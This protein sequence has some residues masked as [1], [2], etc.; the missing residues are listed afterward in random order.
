MRGTEGWRRA[1]WVAGACAAAGVAVA[2]GGVALFTHLAMQ[3]PRRRRRFSTVEGLP[4]E[5]VD[6]AALDGTP[7]CGWYVPAAE[8]R[9]A[10]ILC[11]GY[12]GNRESL[13]PH[14]RF[15]HAA[16]YSCL[17]FDFRAAG[18]SRGRFCTFGA[19]ES[20]DARGAARWL[21]ERDE[22]RGLPIVG[23]GL[24]MG[25]VALL[26]AAP[27]CPAIRAIVAEG[28]YP[29]LAQAIARRCDIL[30][31]KAGRL[32]RPLVLRIIHRRLGADP[33]GISP[34]AVAAELADRPTLF[35]HAEDDIYLDA[36][37]A[38]AFLTRAAEPK[39]LWASAGA[40]HCRAIEPHPAEY[41]EQVLRFLAA[42]NL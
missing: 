30:F 34:L 18:E 31:G 40:P 35:I 17:L 11:H 7:L 37:H 8:P 5:E 3:P 14:A 27:E 39:A 24:S 15:L 20:L 22:T 2:A 29:S 36:E 32:A 13:I 10:A 23:L 41:A 19:D 9:G 33:E 28:I 26:M 42:H 25:A 1:A 21:Q 12:L 6:I 4:C 16:G 38:G